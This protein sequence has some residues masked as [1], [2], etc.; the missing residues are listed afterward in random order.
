[1]GH[2]ACRLKSARALTPQLLRFKGRKTTHGRSAFRFYQRRK[3]TEEQ[4][5]S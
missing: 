2:P 4:V 3:T 1:M 5:H